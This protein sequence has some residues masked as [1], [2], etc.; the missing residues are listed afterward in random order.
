MNSHQGV[1]F[2]P[3]KAPK[4]DEESGSKGS[5]STNA[6]SPSF[7]FMNTKKMPQKALQGSRTLQG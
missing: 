2:I 5:T 1:N 6:C 3:S 7:F 4:A